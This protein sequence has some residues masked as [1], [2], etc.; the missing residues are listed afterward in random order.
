VLVS[1]Q[2][3]KRITFEQFQEENI[4]ILKRIGL[5]LLVALMLVLTACERSASTPPPAT[6][7][8]GTNGTK[9]ATPNV[10]QNPMAIL[11]QYATQTAIAAGGATLPTPTAIGV[12]PTSATGAT[13]VPLITPIITPTPIPGSVLPTPTTAAAA[14][15]PNIVVPTST[16]GKPATY[17]LQAGE[18]PYCIARRFNVNPNDLLAANG[19]TDSSVV[20]AGTVLKIPTTGNP[21]PG[22]PALVPHPANYTVKSGDTVYTVACTYGNADPNQIIYANSLTAPS[23][24]L[25][26]G[27]VIF[28]P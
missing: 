23:Y 3:V 1:R 12:G 26:V 5:I 25:T 16:P 6:P 21:F 15:A 18:F 28:I 27:K 7:I 10:T 17:A 20:Q 4:M 24:P 11:Q 9:L 13:Q 8:S 19:L 2:R 22:N 14:P